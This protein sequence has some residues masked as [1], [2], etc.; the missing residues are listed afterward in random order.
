MYV[1]IQERRV[2]QHCI[3]H[4]IFFVEDNIFFNFSLIIFVERER[5]KGLISST[6]VH[7]V[8]SCRCSAFGKKICRSI[9]PT[10]WANEICP[11]WMVKFAQFEWWNLTNLNGEICQIW[12]VKFAKLIRHL[13][14]IICKKSF[15]P[16]WSKKTSLICWWNWPKQRER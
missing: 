14:N 2:P 4:V 12:M 15:S 7:Q 10:F 16:S 6:F 8:K 9:S 3:M 13:P 11:I 5:G 1:Y